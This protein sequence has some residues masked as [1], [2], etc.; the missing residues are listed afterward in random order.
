MAKLSLA[1]SRPQSAEEQVFDFPVLVCRKISTKEDEENGF[2]TY[3]GQAEVRD[4]K[5]I[6]DDE[7]VREYLAESGDKPKKSGV[8]FAIES[9]LKDHPEF[10]S[11]LN[12][13]ICI[14]AKEAILL[15]DKKII[16]LTK[17]SIINGSQTRGVIRDYLATLGS[18]AEFTAKA[19]FEIIVTRDQDLADEVSIARNYQITVKHLSILGK[20][21]YFDELAQKFTD[22]TGQNRQI[23]TRESDKGD[24]TFIRTEKLLQVITALIPPE[25]WDA[26]RRD[27]EHYAKAF[28]YSSVSGP[29]K[30]FEEVYKGAK[31]EKKEEYV[32]L[33]NFYVAIASQAWEIYENWA[34]GNEFKGLKWK[35]GISRDSKG[36]ILNVVDGIIFPIIAALSVFVREGNGTWK[37][38]PPAM[39]ANSDIVKAAQG[40]FISAAKSNPQS[41]GKDN[42][43][44]QSLYNITQMALRYEG[45]LS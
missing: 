21:G 13:G 17:P 44:Y 11:A 12:G 4:F 38:I 25:L 30:L 15:D 8:H 42:A 22:Y 23:R 19:K 35:N 16:R 18:D 26:V 28:T 24:D 1:Q 3:V 14:V 5:D 20:R 45:K 32:S 31:E 34:A 41:M 7:N 40:Q 43:V 29:L 39:W 36:N 9:T 37:Y 2:L 10:F 33:Y 6:P 27:K